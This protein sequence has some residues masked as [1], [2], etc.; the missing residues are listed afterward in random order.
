MVSLG[1]SLN[2]NPLIHRESHYGDRHTQI[3]NR[4]VDFDEDGFI[5][6]PSDWSPSIA[7]WLAIHDGLNHLTIE[8]WSIITTLREY[9]FKY[10]HVPME[11]QVCH[12]SHMGKHCIDFMFDDKYKEAWRLARLPNPGEE[13]KTYM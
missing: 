9:Y 5:I 10:G 6:D 2:F 11:K 4:I 12:L 8:Q 3:K 7:D 13:I 1:F